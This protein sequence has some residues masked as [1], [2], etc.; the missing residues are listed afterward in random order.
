LAALG[1]LDATNGLLPVDF[2]NPR[3]WAS[4]QVSQI[5]RERAGS[6][7]QRP[8]PRLGAVLA[9]LHPV[10]FLEEAMSPRQRLV[11]VSILALVACVWASPA[12]ASNIVLNPG[13]ET[14]A[15]APWVGNP[16]SSFPWVVTG[17]SGFGHTGQFY[18]ST[19]CVGAPC[20]TPDPNPGGAWL[21]QDLAT[22]PGAT[23]DL[24]FWYAPDGGV[25]NDFAVL[26]NGVQVLDILNSGTGFTFNL[27][28]VAGLVAPGTTTRLEFLGRQDPGFDGLDDVCVDTPRG[29]CA[30][31]SAVPEPTSLVLMGT[32]L[33]GLRRAVR[34][35]R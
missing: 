31:P 5:V 15:L 2:L 6:G 20:M 25:P 4:G 10:N 13:F 33:L 8:R 18:A 9:K 7:H 22:T 32:A 16:S 28:S 29:S 26:W 17:P 27:F 11:F 1:G 19:G 3:L 21:Y 24:S 14:D 12:S 23:Y 35:T 34:R 30:S